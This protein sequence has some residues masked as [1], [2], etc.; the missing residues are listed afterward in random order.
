MSLIMEHN[1]K[2][3][4]S[5][6]QELEYYS[7]SNSNLEE[8]STTSEEDMFLSIQYPS[9]YLHNWDFRDPDRALKYI[10]KN[11]NYKTVI[12]S[13]RSFPNLSLNLL[14]YNTFVDT[15]C[16]KLLQCYIDK[17]IYDCNALLQKWL[18]LQ[19]RYS[20]SDNMNPFII[21]CIL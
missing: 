11:F 12:K 10:M 4:K 20:L 6:Q 3:K 1:S 2:D 9:P 18:E 13:L 14:Y 15:T 8:G 5:S 19:A 17:S 16:Y 7:N 21:Q